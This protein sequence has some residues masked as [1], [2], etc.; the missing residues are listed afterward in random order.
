MPVKNAANEDASNL[1]LVDI[2]A[3]AVLD[4]LAEEAQADQFL[5][6]IVDR[7]VALQRE[8]LL[9]ANQE[10]LVRAETNLAFSKPQP[11]T[12]VISEVSAEE[13]EDQRETLPSLLHHLEVPAQPAAAQPLEKVPSTSIP[14]LTTTS[15]EI[16]RLN[17]SAPLNAVPIGSL[18]DKTLHHRSPQQMFTQTC[19]LR[20]VSHEHGN[21]KAITN[22]DILIYWPHGFGDWVFLSYI[23][24]LLEPSNRYWVTRFGDDSVTLFEGSDYARPLYLGS[25][26]PLCGD[27]ST[28]G[29]QHFGLHYEAIDGTEQ[30]LSLP[31]A[32]AHQCE[33]LGIGTMLWSCNPEIYGYSSYP[34]HTK[35]RALLPYLASPSLLSTTILER[36]LVSAI[37]FKVV[38]WLTQWV[39]SRLRSFAGFGHRK[40]CVIARNGYSSHGKNWGHLWRDDMPSGKQREGEECRDFMRL[41]LRKDP[42]WAFLVMEDVLFKGDDTVCSEELHAYSYAEIFGPVGAA[43]APYGQ[44]MK[45]ICNLA[46]LVV[47][48]PVGPYHLAMAKPDLPVVGLWT[49]HMP[50]WYDEPKDVSRHLLSRNVQDR[51][52]R[53][54]PGSFSRTHEIDFSSRWLETRV[55]PGAQVLESVEDLLYSGTLCTGDSHVQNLGMQPEASHHVQPEASHQ[56]FVPPVSPSLLPLPSL[57][58]LLEEVNEVS[59]LD[60]ARLTVMYQCLLDVQEL[61]GEAIEL[62]VYRG[63]TARMIA[64]MLRNREVHL[65][66]TFNGMPRPGIEDTHKEGDF[67]DTSLKSVQRLLSDLDNVKLYAGLFPETLPEALYQKQFCFVHCDAD[68]YRSTVD[69]LEFF[70]PRMTPGGVMVFDDYDWHCCP[71]IKSALDDY[72]QNKPESIV[73]KQK[74]QA[75]IVKL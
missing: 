20:V 41:L 16:A 46:D 32:L 18:A 70:Y 54:R 45:V 10:E 19:S 36:P 66:D 65:F 23:M 15:A 26:S 67:A 8:E 7:V 56:R 4:Q 9:H 63:G 5:D 58:D 1:P 29:N 31:L 71:G 51:G 17:N 59:L 75:I 61:P 47:G 27:G 44:V 35:A 55:I 49:E 60:G 39:E 37:N 22:T 11:E 48:V 62:G 64:R 25:G 57:S 3:Q 73:V 52:A 43:T 2:I 12:Y 6:L 34:F 13:H 69:F 72:L 42:Q 68:L 21:F 28:F 50:S 74:Y 30:M 33:K 38:S 24:P 53:E 14:S 40:L